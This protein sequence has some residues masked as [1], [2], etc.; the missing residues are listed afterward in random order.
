MGFRENLKETME[1][2]G[3]TTQELA[4]KSGVKRGTINHYLMTNPQEPSVGN[5]VRIAQAL[6]VSVEYLV[7]GNTS[8]SRIPMNK[9]L[10]DFINTYSLLSERQKRA[11][12]DIV[13]LLREA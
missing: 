11:V 2:C 5:A 9:A 12:Q 1:Y 10:I 6:H 8:N 7:T 3:M 4:E 13:K